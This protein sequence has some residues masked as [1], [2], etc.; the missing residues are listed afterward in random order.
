MLSFKFFFDQIYSKIFLG[1]NNP[2]FYIVE[3]RVRIV[4]YHEFSHGIPLPLKLCCQQQHLD[5][6]KKEEE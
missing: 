3:I 4:G 1:P 6:F 2:N 5:E